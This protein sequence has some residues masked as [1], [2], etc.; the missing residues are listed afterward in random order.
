MGSKALDEKLRSCFSQKI[1]QLAE[2]A[3]GVKITPYKGM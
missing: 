3:S 1:H 2:R